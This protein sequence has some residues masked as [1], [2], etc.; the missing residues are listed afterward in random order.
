MKPMHI[1]IVRS[2]R[3]GLSSM[4]QASC[5][6]A[7]PVLA[8]HYTDVRITNIDTM[9]DL[10]AL[11]RRNPDL[12]FLGMEYILA[13]PK[14][15]SHDSDKIWLA[16]HLDEHGIAYTGSSHRA[17][18]LGRDKQLAK[19]RVLDAGLDTAAFYIVQQDCLMPVAGHLLAFPLFVKPTSRGGG[20]GIDSN[21]VVYTAGQLRAK[22]RALA[23]ELLSD[24]LVEEYLPGRE[25]S[26]A[27]LMN[28][29]TREYAAMP[30]ELIAPLG[31]GDA[32]ILSSEVKSSNTEQ[33]IA[34]TD[35]AVKA[36]VSE[37]A[38]NTFIAL[39]GRDYGRID[40]RLDAR[41]IPHFLEA[42]LIPSLI[43]GYGSF[44]KAC[45]IN[46]GLDYESMILRIAALG[47]NRH[48]GS[49][50]GDQ[51]LTGKF[52]AHRESIV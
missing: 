51:T 27:I 20:L 2:T 39:G 46:I 17:H 44:P 15:G 45:T 37:L 48:T 23:V 33:A 1:E 16:Q 3:P 4:S 5:A 7:R 43:D 36:R 34:V 32:R 30:I 47:L 25:F 35:R 6:A 24:S 9:D 38:M 41:G 18:Q 21:S 42:N 52:G 28:E 26:V 8:K 11:V 22:T 19:Q 12:V 49:H 14:L 50:L 13:R 40:I 31:P 10:E 29:H